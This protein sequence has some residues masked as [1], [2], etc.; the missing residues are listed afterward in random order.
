MDVNSLFH[1]LE[2]QI[3]P[4]Y[5]AK[6]D[7]RLPL[8]WIDLMRESIR[9]IVPVFNTHRMVQ[10]YTERL[11]EPSAAAHA[12]VIADSC[13]KAVELPRWK[14]NIRRDWP[15]VTL[16]DVG[17]R[18]GNGSNVTVGDA[19][20]VSVRVSLGPIAP[21]FVR[22]QALYGETANG[23]IRNSAT[24]DLKQVEKLGPG[25]FRFAGTIPTA[26]SGSYGL[27]VRVVPTHPNLIQNHELRLITWA[28]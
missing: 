26:E 1:V 11:Y 20:E 8:A 22:V 27:S 21:E 4:L 6:P 28:N 10:E 12:T 7:G 19:I 16:T 17:I 9:T 24:I 14:D 15:Q 3:L 23:N 25:A 5:Y 18:T 13:K 2:T